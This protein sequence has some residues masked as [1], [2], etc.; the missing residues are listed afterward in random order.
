M[1]KVLLLNPPGDRLYLR[2]SYCSKVSKAAY[3]T[4]PIDLLAVSGYLCAR[5]DCLV[6]DAMAERC[7][8]TTALR[9][10]RAADPDLVVSL[11]GQASFR[12]DLS[13]YRSLKQVLPGAQLVVSG[14]VGFD[15]PER[16]L[17]RENTID[18]ILMDYTSR[19]WL[20]YIDG[21]R[22]AA[23]DIAYLSQGKFTCLRSDAVAEFSI[24]VPRLE[25]FP[26]RKYR[27]P[28]ARRLPYAGV[29]TDFGCP[30]RCDFCIVGQLPFKLRSIA[31][32]LDELASL[33]KLGIKYFSF[34]D[35]T[36]GADRQRTEIL[37][38]G[39]RIRNI[40]LPWG[41]FF[42]A[43]LLDEE[44]LES[45]MSAGCELLIMGVESGSQD[46]L[47]RHH[48]GLDLAKVRRAFGLCRRKG[49]R[50]VATFIIG[51]PGESR[52]G[53][54]ETVKLALELDPDFAS[55]NLPVAKPLTPLRR[56][57]ETRGWLTTREG[58]QS[59][60]SNLAAGGI[61]PALLRE[62]RS[63]ALRRFYLRPAYWAKRLA[64][65]KSMGELVTNLREAW[66][67]LAKGA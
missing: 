17:R 50:T 2:D 34:G 55:F 63:E 40:G 60:C 20:P 59:S 61:P 33:K 65:I 43:D 14:D 21:D 58:D 39:I 32:V 30:Y 22:D 24:G 10:A 3:L 7:S 47:D 18:G 29:I 9:R 67:M 19:R 36:F 44:Y 56:E 16:L 12:N 64:G 49:V 5:H 37:L 28:F 31:E 13:F 62:W 66:A 4:P 48:K 52:Q 45:L 6:M 23:R 15:D 27:M 46:L 11:F 54:E 1:A 42:R 53:F 35:Q 57:A 26:Y 25:A 38:Q 8:F 51:L 41:C